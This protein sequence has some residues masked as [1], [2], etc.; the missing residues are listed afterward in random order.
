MSTPFEAYRGTLQQRVA[1]ASA[2]AGT[3]AY[4]L[5]HSGYLDVNLDAGDRHDVSQTFDFAPQSVLLRSVIRVA[6]P[7]T[8]PDDMTWELQ[9]LLNGDVHYHRRIDVAGRVLTLFD[10]AVRLEADPPTDNVVTFRLVLV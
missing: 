6:A 1:T 9:A 8:L 2:V 3:H 5:G 4:E 7:P 10:I